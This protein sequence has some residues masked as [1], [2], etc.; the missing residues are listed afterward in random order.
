M[1]AGKQPENSDHSPSASLA[2]KIG[3]SASGLAR[4]AF[5]QPSGMT[6]TLASLSEQ[7]GK[8]GSSSGAR[9]RGE[10]SNQRI[11]G[12]FL[13]R[14]TDSVRI[15]NHDS[16]RSVGH[17]DPQ[18]IQAEFDDFA[19][20][21]GFAARNS[22]NVDHLTNSQMHISDKGK[23]PL[24]SASRDDNERDTKHTGF[25]HSDYAATDGAAVVD[26]LSSPEFSA[27]E[28]SSGVWDQESVNPRGFL[29]T[30]STSN[31]LNE[32][33]ASPLDLIPDYEW[34]DTGQESHAWY[35]ILNRYHDEVW[36]DNLPLVREARKELEQASA[37]GDM[38]PNDRP[39]LRRLKMLLQHLKPL[40]R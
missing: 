27:D 6:E 30:V 5:V 37:S 8:A 20:T 3:E 40:D 38:N 24:H 28:E 16:F 21:P 12:D 17:D 34:H 29:G 31:N 36:G 9:E 18:L 35:D 13:S 11:S 7:G 32:R 39:A 25:R 33:L 15:S 14:P 10:S 19:R 4:A 22:A 23:S 2:Q 26:L 1:N